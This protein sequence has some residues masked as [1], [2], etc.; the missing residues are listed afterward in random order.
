[1]GPN[2]QVFLPHHNRTASYACAA[3]VSSAD[4]AV[5]STDG[6]LGIYAHAPGSSRPAPI[7]TPSCTQN[8]RSKPITVAAR[9]DG[10]GKEIRRDRCVPHRC[11]ALREYRGIFPRAYVASSGVS[12]G[13]EAD[14]CTP[15]LTNLHYVMGT[16]PAS[17]PTFYTLWSLGSNWGGLPW[18][19]VCTCGLLGR[20]TPLGSPVFA[21]GT[22][23]AP[24]IRVAPWSSFPPSQPS[25]S[26]IQ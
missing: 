11:E 16:V 1:V 13:R 9:T 2:G 3:T 23:H 21:D 22:L 4:L 12:R 20:W 15:A 10:R 18:P 5:H 19:R 14:N 25:V 7:A 6:F 8:H 24:A 17:L 26:H